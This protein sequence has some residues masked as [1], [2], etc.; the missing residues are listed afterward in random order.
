MQSFRGIV[1]QGAEDDMRTL[2]VATLQLSPVIHGVSS[3]LSLGE[4]K[5]EWRNEAA[6]KRC[7]PKPYCIYQ[8]GYSS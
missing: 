7:H 5:R 1:D 8:P 6:R 2:L 3:A 4:F